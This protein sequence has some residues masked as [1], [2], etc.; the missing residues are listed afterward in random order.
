MKTESSFQ[1][2]LISELKKMFPGCL[3]LKLDPNYKQGLP[4]LLI[5]FRSKWAALECK[6]SATAVRQPNQE[7]YVNL[8]NNLSFARFIHPK[9]KGEVL[10]ELQQAFKR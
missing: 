3:V 4:D 10:H 1:K 5:L 6:R 8:M 9:N 2:K 7:Y